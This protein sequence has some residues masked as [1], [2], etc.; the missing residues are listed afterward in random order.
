VQN[1]IPKTPPQKSVRVIN[2]VLDFY[3]FAPEGTRS[4]AHNKQVIRKGTRTYG[5]FHMDCF[6]I[7]QG[8]KTRSCTHIA[9]LKIWSKK[10]TLSLRYKMAARLIFTAAAY[11]LRG[12]G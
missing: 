3:A 4:G 2:E 12:V 10:R 9:Q 11:A 5:I 8:C 1:C 7:V 6:S